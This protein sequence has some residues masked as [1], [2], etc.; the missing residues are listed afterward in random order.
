MNRTVLTST[1]GAVLALGL[2][3]AS[4]VASPDMLVKVKQGGYPAQNCQYCHVAALPKKDTFKPED[5][6][7][8]GKWLLEEKAKQNANAVNLDWLKNYP[9]GKEQKQ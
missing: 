2:A 4:T 1:L 5:L 3:P 8:R 7:E 6:N 9:G